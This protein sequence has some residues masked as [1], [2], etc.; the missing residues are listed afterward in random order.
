MTVSEPSSSAAGPA[1]SQRRDGV[2]WRREHGN[3]P[4]FSVVVPAYNEEAGIVEFHRRLSVVMNAL[5]AWE[6]IYVNDGSRDRTGPFIEALREADNHVALVNLSRNFGKEIATT[7]GLDHARGDAVIVIDADL[8]DPPELIPELVAGWREGYDMIYAQ[9]R[10]REGETWLKRTTADLF[11]RLMQ[12][13][14]GVQLPRNTGDFRLMSRRVVDAL[15]QLREQHRFMKGLF[16]WVGFPT[17]A[18]LYNRAPRHSGETKWNYPKLWTLAI[19][20][21]T[22][23]TVMPLKVATY[24][25]LAVAIVAVIFGGQVIVKTILFGNSVAGYPSLMTVILFLG[26]VQLI[27]L[28]VIGEYLGRVFNETKGRP[29]YLVERYS[30]SRAASSVVAMPA[31]VGVGSPLATTGVGSSADTGHTSPQI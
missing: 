15:L 23:F 30:P 13:L 31:T 28:G 7:A 18:V 17:K 1:S 19:E 21:I 26:G 3:A 14:G 4:L 8:Q 27:T 6:V 16:A 22:S 24:L 10:I 11:Y 29:L 12:N 2:A 25:G 9:R 5:G 20:G